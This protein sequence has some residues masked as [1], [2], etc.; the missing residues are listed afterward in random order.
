MALSL[1]SKEVLSYLE[2]E[3]GHSKESD[4]DFFEPTQANKRKKRKHRALQD[5]SIKYEVKSDVS[6]AD[7][8]PFD[9][10]FVSVKENE[11]R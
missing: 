11:H 7:F 5:D 8:N 3:A 6:D 2:N 10:D 1:Q 9:D 4:D